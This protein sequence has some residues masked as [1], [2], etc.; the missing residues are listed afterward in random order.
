MDVPD[1]RAQVPRLLRRYHA[2]VAGGSRATRRE[3]CRQQFLEYT[4]YYLS[5]PVSLVA[6]FDTENDGAPP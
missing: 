6:T 3:P 4:L 1:Q 5:A 2:L